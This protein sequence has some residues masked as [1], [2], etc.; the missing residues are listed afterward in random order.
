M[1]EA[2]PITNGMSWPVVLTLCTPVMLLA[3]MLSSMNAMKQAII[4]KVMTC[5]AVHNR[6]SSRLY[7]WLV[8]ETEM[9]VHNTHPAGVDSAASFSSISTPRLHN[10]VKPCRS[11]LKGG[12]SL[13]LTVQK[14][15]SIL[16]DELTPICC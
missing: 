10:E 11:S 2:M 4:T 9:R 1:N 7:S 14:L 15:L 3:D 5:I 8:I 6:L 13:A 12:S 16:S